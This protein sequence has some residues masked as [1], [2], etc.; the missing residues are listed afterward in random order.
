AAQSGGHHF[1]AYFCVGAKRKE[2]KLE[3]RARIPFQNSFGARA[4]DARGNAAM[5]CQERANER[6][7][8]RHARDLADET[9]GS[10]HAQIGAQS[11]LRSLVDLELA[12]CARRLVRNDAGPDEPV[13][14]G[15]ADLQHRAKAFVL[16][17][18][19]TQAGALPRSL[20]AR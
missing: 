17:I 1:V 13:R 20:R 19:F 18:S 16:Q 11:V 9:I 3:L 10:D 7:A 4:S 6:A 2:G 12:P 5:T 15:R 8:R 14:A